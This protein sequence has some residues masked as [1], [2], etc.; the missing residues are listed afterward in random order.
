[1]MFMNLKLYGFQVAKTASRQNQVTKQ[2]QVKFKVYIMHMLVNWLSHGG[3]QGKRI[4]KL[5]HAEGL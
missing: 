3:T 2:S 1:M 5:P 4:S